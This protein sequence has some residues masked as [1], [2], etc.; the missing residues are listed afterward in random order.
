MFINMTFRTSLLI[1][2]QE[3][4]KSSPQSFNL[5]QHNILSMFTLKMILDNSKCS[6]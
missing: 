3:R 6:S 2:F 4:E 5:N 1:Q